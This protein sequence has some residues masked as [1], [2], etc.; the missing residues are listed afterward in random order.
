KRRGFV[1]TSTKGLEGV[2][3]T[4]SSV[5][6][7]INDQLTYVGYKIDDLA[8]NSSFEEVIYLL[9]NLKLPTKQELDAFR[10][11]ISSKMELPECRLVHFHSYDLSTVHPMAALLTAVS[12][13]GLYDSEADVLDETANKRK[14]IRIRAKIA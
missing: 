11:E 4:Q 8:E 14:A 1:M 3:A 5:S 6:S 13:L 10:A 7:I 2:V 12:L 9:W